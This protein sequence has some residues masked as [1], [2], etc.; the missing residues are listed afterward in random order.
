MYVFK[1][2]VIIH[3]LSHLK[4][5]YGIVHM[6]VCIRSHICMHM[7]TCM[8]H[9]MYVF[10]VIIHILSHLEVRYGI[11][12][13][14]LVEQLRELLFS[15]HVHTIMYLVQGNPHFSKQRYL[16]ELPVSARNLQRLEKKNFESEQTRHRHIG[17]CE[18]GVWLKKFLC[19][20]LRF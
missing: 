11:V 10:Y 13:A 7:C 17:P 8:Y 16:N 18:L 3:I 9:D 12:H 2:Y 5:R 14:A 15:C 1:V 4:V 20:G 19:A 6:Y